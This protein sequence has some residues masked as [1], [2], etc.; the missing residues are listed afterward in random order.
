MLCVDTL[1]VSI[2]NYCQCV[3]AGLDQELA[4]TIVP[5]WIPSFMGIIL[6]FVRMLQVFIARLKKKDFRKSAIT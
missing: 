5:V 2:L 1:S 3:G 6:I 4:P